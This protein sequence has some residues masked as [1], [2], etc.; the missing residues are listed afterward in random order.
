MPFVGHSYVIRMSSYMPRMSI[1]INIILHVI[2]MSLVCNSYVISM[3]LKF[4][5][6]SSICHSYAINVIRMYL[7]V[8]RMSHVCHPYVAS[9][10]FTPCEISHICSVVTA[11]LTNHILRD[12][13]L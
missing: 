2:R 1:Q 5:R 13:S 12:S 10:V 7:Y 8:T 11:A 4:A 9:V 6:M 3:S